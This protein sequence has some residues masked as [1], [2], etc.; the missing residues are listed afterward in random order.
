[1]IVLMSR[2]VLQSRDQER[3][4]LA[5]R[6]REDC[7]G[8]AGLDVFVSPWHRLEGVEEIR[9]VEA[10]M[11]GEGLLVEVKPETHLRGM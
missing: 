9:D 7:V 11:D 8:D 6:G 1:M 5:L 2:V 10:E 3:G 4:H